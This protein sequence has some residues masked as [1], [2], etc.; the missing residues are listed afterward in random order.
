MASPQP[1]ALYVHFPFCLSVCPYCDFVVYAGRAAKGPDARIDRFVGALVREI[2]LRAVPGSKLRSVYLGGGTPSLMTPQ[3][4]ADILQAADKAFG[5]AGDA[6]LTM[7]V[8]PGVSERGDL[9]GFR[10]AGANRVSIGAQSLDA[11]ELRRLGR[12]HSPTD[13]AATVAQARAGGFDS[14]SVDL[15][16][17]VHGQTISTWRDTL[18]GTIELEPDHISAYALSLDEHAPSA[19]HVPVSRG[20]ASWRS[21]ARVQQDEDRAA[22]MYELADET[23]ARAGLNWYEI[24]NWAQPGRASRHNNVYWQ[25]EPWQAVGPGAHSFDGLATRRWNDAPLSGYLDALDRGDLPPGGSQL[26]S[27]EEAAAERM[28][29]ALRTPRGITRN[30]ALEILAW[31][32]TNDLLE[33]FGDRVRLT[34]R[35]RLLSNELFERLMPAATP[36]AA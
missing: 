25:S 12:R 36:T 23:F 6:E 26:M 17:D 7:E 5:I 21:R 3:H 29:L 31:G 2:G 34:R 10:A 14:L 32:L 20:A 9:A 8:N 22:A 28:M 18:S 19:D 35:G 27:D 11:G 30:D 15:L 13:V 1:V 16:Y 33:P 4:A 24:S